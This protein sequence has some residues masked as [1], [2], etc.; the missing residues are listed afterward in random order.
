MSKVNWQELMKEYAADETASYRKL[1][2]KYGVSRTSVEH[3][4]RKMGWV[5]LRD[6]MLAKVRQKLPDKLSETLAQVTARHVESA[7][8]LQSKGLE[9]I[10]NGQAPI[11]FARDARDYLVDGIAIERRALGLDV[12]NKSQGVNLNVTMSITELAERIKARVETP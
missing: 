7:K 9:V 3:Q 4:A 11:K 5:K 6:N 1:A 12:I 10:R 2:N 8:L